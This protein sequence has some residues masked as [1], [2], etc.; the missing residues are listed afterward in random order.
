MGWNSTDDP[1]YGPGPDD[2]QAIGRIVEDDLELRQLRR[3]IAALQEME[4]RTAD[5]ERRLIELRAR[6]AIF[7][8]RISGRRRALALVQDLRKPV[9][10][11]ADPGQPSSEDPANI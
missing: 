3:Q 10:E 6:A 11:P 1:C 4:T 9:G 7:Q 2:S 8:S 5:D